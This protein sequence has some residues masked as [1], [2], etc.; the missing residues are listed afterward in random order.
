V[1]ELNK[2]Q[3]VARPNSGRVFSSFLSQHDWPDLTAHLIFWPILIVGFTVDLW[4]K[5]LIF[6][7]L[8]IGESYTVINGFFQLTAVENAGAAFGLA[9]EQ[10]VLL[11]SVSAVAS[12]VILGI[13]FFGGLK[14]RLAQVAIG[15]FIAG[16]LGNLYDRIFNDGLVRDFI[17]I[18]YWP[19]KHWPAF[20]IADSMLCI[21]VGLL[22]IT[23]LHTSKK[24]A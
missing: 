21:A 14:K 5:N 12:V 10:R 17:D 8:H 19:G 1:T 4:T 9:N 13:F 24:Q 6:Q 18:T 16:V 7:W 3:D 11:V 2:E 15:L 23:S 20:N 22:I